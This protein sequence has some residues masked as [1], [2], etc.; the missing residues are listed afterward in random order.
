MPLPH[1]GSA[2]SQQFPLDLHQSGLD[3]SWTGVAPGD[4]GEPRHKL[5]RVAVR[6]WYSAKVVGFKDLVVGGVFQARDRG[7]GSHHD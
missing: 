5:I 2:T 1:D 4:G 3:E 6:R 7:F